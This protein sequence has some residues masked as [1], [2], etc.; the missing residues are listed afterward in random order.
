MLCCLLQCVHCYVFFFFLK[1]KTPYELRISDWSSDVC[2]SDLDV[3]D[4]SAGGDF[5]TKSASVGAVD[6]GSLEVLDMQLLVAPFVKAG[7]GR[8]MLDES[9][10]PAYIGMHIRSGAGKHGR[11][12]QP[13]VRGSIVIMEA[14]P[15]GEARRGDLVPERGPFRGSDAI[16]KLEIR[17]R[18][19]T[20]LN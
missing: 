7:R 13:L 10:R 3:I 12:V 15:R 1:Q 11:Q 18:K 17:D 9:L 14:H 20:R 6:R 5:D 16:M 4:V 2:S 8:D 19:R